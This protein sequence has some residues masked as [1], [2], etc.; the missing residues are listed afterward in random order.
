MLAVEFLI[1]IRPHEV[2]G[3]AQS[4]EAPGAEARIDALA[5]RRRRRVAKVLRA[6]LWRGSCLNTS[7]FQTIFPDFRSSESTRHDSP[8]SIAVVTKTCSPH[9]MGDDHDSPGIGVVQTTLS[10]A[11]HFSVSPVSVEIPWCVGPRNCGQ[12]SAWSKTTE[13]NSIGVARRTFFILAGRLKNPAMGNSSLH[14]RAR[15]PNR[16]LRQDS[17]D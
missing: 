11:L 4:R 14:R 16:A 13:S 15:A 2:A 5:I 1:A 3:K 9:T 7:L 8:L 10:V 12:F 17:A 6:C